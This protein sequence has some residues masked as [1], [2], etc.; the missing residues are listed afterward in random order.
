MPQTAPDSSFN[1]ERHRKVILVLD[2]VESVRLMESDEQGFI[3]RWH[4]FVHEAR[5]IVAPAFLGVFRKSTGDGFMLEFE[6]AAAAVDAAI[7]LRRRARDGNLLL[8]AESHMHVRIAAHLA[9]Y[10]ADEFDIYGSGVN[11]AN[12]L[13]S[14]A[15][16]GDIVVS[17]SV[18]DLLVASGARL[19][20]LGVHSLRHLSRPAHVFRVLA[21]GSRAASVADQGA[22]S[23]PEPP[24]ASGGEPA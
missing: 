2:T 3:E 9:D 14:L 21:A 6:H 10:V 8:G 20:D 11:L 18:R 22:R 4:Q 5:H 17:A 1:F 13:L 19:E 23:P 7:E 15:G 12:R 16:P 24:R